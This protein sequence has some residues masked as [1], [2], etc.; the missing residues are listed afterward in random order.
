MAG[1]LM[2]LC[3][4]NYCP[5]KCGTFSMLEYHLFNN[6]CPIKH[7]ESYAIACESIMKNLISETTTIKTLNPYN[8]PNEYLMSLFIKLASIINDNPCK[9]YDEPYYIK[10]A[11]RIIQEILCILYSKSN[12]NTSLSIKYA[13]LKYLFLTRMNEIRYQSLM[14]DM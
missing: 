13:E 9:L 12:E 7:E 2:A 5:H 8:L 3:A 6:Y 10:Y 14:N 1:G 4:S 11:S